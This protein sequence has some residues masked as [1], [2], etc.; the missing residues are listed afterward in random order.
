MIKYKSLYYSHKCIENVYT[1]P[2]TNHAEPIYEILLFIQGNASFNIM[3]KL[4]PLSPYDL[5]II[6]ADSFHFIDFNDNKI[7]ERVMFKFK[8]V[9]NDDPDLIEFYAEPKV[10]NI[11]NNA[12]MMNLFD[13]AK[14]YFYAFEQE[15]LDPLMD[16]LFQ[17]LQILLKHV[18]FE[19]ATPY[20]ISN[21][22]VLQMIKLI[23]ENLD[24]NLSAKFFA[25]RLFLS[26]SYLKH[27]FSKTMHVGLNHYINNLRVLKARRLIK[28]GSRPNDIYR[29][30]G[31]DSYTT[32]YREYKHFTGKSPTQDSPTSQITIKS[33]K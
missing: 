4:Y 8:I 27:L 26:E 23:S 5:A 9:K 15:D 14:K 19:H 29:Q 28:A 32:F 18:D 11:R 33:N 21:P 2:Y 20:S 17:E 10:I 24:Q 7:Y 3:G 16:A 25:E 1:K 13:R 12:N 22:T 30:C 6:P 31:F